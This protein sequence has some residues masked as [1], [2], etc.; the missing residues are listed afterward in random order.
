MPEYK[1]GSYAKESPTSIFTVV[2]AEANIS[3]VVGTAPIN[4]T[5]EKNVNELHRLATY[6]DAVNAFGFD[7]DYDKYSLSE[8][9]D[10]F[11]TKYKVAPVYFVNV[12]DPAKH[13]KAATPET[14]PQINSQVLLS[15]KGAIKSSVIVAVGKDSKK[16]DSDYTLAFNADNLMVVT[17]LDG[18]TIK[19][20]DELTVTYDV[21]DSSKVKVA[22][23]IGGVDVAGKYSGIELAQQVYPQ[24]NEVLGSLIAP[25][26]SKDITVDAA[27]LANAKSLNTVFKANVIIDLDTSKAKTYADAVSIKQK[28]G[29]TNELINLCFGDLYLGDQK[30]N[31]ST[32]VAA[33]KQLI[34]ANNDGIPNQNPSNKAYFTNGFKLNGI[35]LFLDS[36]QAEYLNKNGIIVARKLSSGWRCWGNRTACF[37]ADTDVKNYDIAVRDMFNFLMNTC[38][39]NTEQMVDGQIDR[40]LVLRIQTTIQGW[41]DGLKGTGKIISGSISFTQEKNPLSELLMGNVYFQL[42]FTT[43]TTASSITTEITFNANDLKLIFNE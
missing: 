43:A 27:L 7:P 39:L 1:H 17:S 12:L 20:T 3:F 4:L 8:A 40:A 33:L 11:F 42:Q 41:L 19:P 13:K 29:L 30:Y 5:D 9:I 14:N 22:D 10:V 28:A 15:Q 31:Q 2:N 38:V 36:K 35:D 24:F 21:L 6:A 18:G 23:I 34:A 37:P 26:W 32:V 16:L 25:G